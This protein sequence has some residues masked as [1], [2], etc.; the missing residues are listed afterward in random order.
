MNVGRVK[1]KKCSPVIYS[2]SSVVTSN[3]EKEKKTTMMVTTKVWIRF[4]EQQAPLDPLRM[5]EYYYY[6]KKEKQYLLERHLNMSV[7][8]DLC[9]NQDPPNI[10]MDMYLFPTL[11]PQI[12]PFRSWKK[13]LRQRYLTENKTWKKTKRYSF[14]MDA[15][16]LHDNRSNS[17]SI[18]GFVASS[19]Q[20]MQRLKEK[21]R[22]APPPSRKSQKTAMRLDY[23]CYWKSSPCLQPLQPSLPLIPCFTLS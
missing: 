11:P 2:S 4:E 23:S 22:L 12:S 15:I 10:P 16:H 3:E 8:M 5:V 7:V 18:I 14:K 13:Q 9:W 21:E 6:K 17:E 20:A 1:R 19:N